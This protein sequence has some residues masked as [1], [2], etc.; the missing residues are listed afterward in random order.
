LAAAFSHWA[1]VAGLNSLLGSEALM[2][3]PAC[4]P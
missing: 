1:R 3:T 4:L 2:V